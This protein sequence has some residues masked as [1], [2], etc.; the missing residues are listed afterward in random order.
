MATILANPPPVGGFDAARWLSEWTEHG[1]IYILA[2]DQLHLRRMRPLDPSSSD[3]LDRL[4]T[5]MLRAG[6]GPAIA[7]H[8]LR[9]RE[10]EII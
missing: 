6:A 7:G 5:E 9:Q 1:G 8:L 10:G 3:H 2:G 4:R